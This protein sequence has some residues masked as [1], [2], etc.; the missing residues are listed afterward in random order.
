MDLG[1][2]VVDSPAA[3]A[4][5]SDIVITI[6]GY[7]SDVRRVYFGEGEEKGVLSVRAGGVWWVVVLRGLRCVV[8]TFLS[9]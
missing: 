2:T 6:V 1:A 5:A 3:V 8:P 9:G 7:P 4:A